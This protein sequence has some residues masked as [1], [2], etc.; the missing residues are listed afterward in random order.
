MPYRTLRVPLLLSIAAALVTIGLKGAAYALTNSAGLLSDAL[1]SGVNLLAAVV[2]YASL[3][4]ANRPAD[5]EHTYGHEKIEFFS[6]GIEGILVAVAGVGSIAYGVRALVS[7]VPLESL[8][9]GIAL[10][11]VASVINLG[12]GLMLLRVGRAHGSIILEADGHHLMSDVL[13]SAGVLAGL[14]FVALTGVREL[15][16]VVAMVVGASIIRT[17]LR[18]V[19]RSYDGLM[20]RA[21]P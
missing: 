21:L 1:E 19:R 13:T 18:L 6:S 15:D 17:G 9:L 14:G 2:A 8:G 11:V 10:S 4:Y 5:Q 16:A 7:P 12:V 3:A 20:D